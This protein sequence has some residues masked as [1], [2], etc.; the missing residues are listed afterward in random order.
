MRL[1]RLI[2]SV[3][4]L[5]IH[6]TSKK[7]TVII[8][9]DVSDEDY[10]KALLLYK[11]RYEELNF[12]KKGEIKDRFDD[13]EDQATLFIVKNLSM[14]IVAL[15]RLILVENKTSPIIKNS[16]EAKHFVMENQS[17]KFYEFASFVKTENTSS[18]APLVLIKAMYIFSIENKADF[19]VMAIGQ[20]ILKRYLGLFGDKLAP[21]GK[22]LDYPGEP[23]YPYVFSFNNADK[24]VSKN[25]GINRIIRGYIQNV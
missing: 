4:V 17:K 20:S 25:K 9:S 13:F 2:E 10:F 3:E 7:L 24:R 12:I 22:N 11:K 18:V 8:G 15:G 16:P 6:K 14:K 19:W 5:R 23:V 21:C 1:S